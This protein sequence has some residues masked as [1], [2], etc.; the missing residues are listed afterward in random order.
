MGNTT[1][2]RA[3]GIMLACISLSLLVTPLAVHAEAT[4]DL[5]GAVLF[6]P[7]NTDTRLQKAV[8]MLLDE[9][10]RR[11]GLRW[12][13]THEWP[14]GDRVAVAVGLAS[15]L[16]AFPEAVTTPS[17]APEGYALRS[18][19]G[20]VIVA[21][22]DPRG[23]LFGVGRLLLEMRISRGK[24]LLA[25]GLEIFTAPK[26]PMRGHQLGYRPKVNTYDGWTPE[27]YEQYI[28]DLAVFGSNA[29]ELIPPRSD[30]APDSPHFVMPQIDMIASVS[31]LADDYGID[32]WM[33][34]PAM[35]V[36]F[37]K[38]E[39]VGA[40]LEE[41]ERVLSQ[42]PRVDA[43]FVPSG[44][45]G[46]LDPGPLFAFLEQAA[47]AVHRVHPNAQIWVSTQSFRPDQHNEFVELVRTRQPD[48]LDGVVFGPQNR[49]TLR[50]LRETL[51]PQY[52]IR[53]YPDITHS[54]KCQFP[55]PDWD[56][57][58]KLTEQ[59]EVINPRPTDFA[60]IIRMY[61]DDTIGFISY[62][63]GCNDDVNKFV[64]SAL[65]WNPDTP[66]IDVLRAYSRYFIGSEFE[67]AFA[68]G[69]LAL[70]RNWR[71]PLLANRG[72]FTTLAQFQD[73]ERGATPQQLLNWRFQ[74][75]LYRAYYDAYTARRLAYETELEAQALDVLRRAP[76][77]GAPL[78][79][80]QAETI[81]D[82]AVLEPVAQDLRARVFE[83]AE[84]LY[85]SIRMQ[86]S[87][88]RYRAIEVGRGA[89]LDLIDTP[90]NDRLWLKTRFA[91]IRDA[92]PLEQL[93]QINEI[94]NWSDPGPG[95]FYDR[96]GD[97]LQQAHLVRA[98]GAGAD[99]EYREAP[100]LGVDY[101]PGLKLSWIT[102][103]ETRY[104][105]PLRLQYD[106]LDSSAQYKVR[107][108]YAGDNMDAKMRLVAN[109]QIEVHPYIAKEQPIRPVE[110]DL[111]RE[112]TQSGG[113]T[114]SWT[115]EPG[116]RGGGRGCQVA[117]VWLIRK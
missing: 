56:P 25:D 40:A 41:W 36:N 78:A 43:V 67:D 71:G 94:V 33:W 15:A 110:F 58:F 18:G 28:R 79:M 20:R 80:Q 104:D 72:V 50:E 91:E 3:L 27:M 66:V 101:E 115:Q 51:P 107:V 95:G 69:L 1:L 32:F 21:G 75:G 55:V 5:S 35:G 85:Q 59:R 12:E 102:Y 99:P 57:A 96:L 54:I 2:H 29:I 92:R 63:E 77:L 98:P 81:L 48:F 7:A 45:P 39:T 23:V 22:N 60:N 26:Y 89:N 86:L 87:V 10:E 16:S 42:L 97:T 61:D 74:Q 31:Q 11:S 49:S 65:G 70:E 105:A 64:W 24:I 17:A 88:P 34:Y 106:G 30:D 46:R 109:G 82:R 47:P 44:D 111:P 84:A 68:Q 117:E 14:S 4:I 13:E 83:L 37:D 108:V 38:P 76:E 90:L 53:H 114:L 52:P 73:M 19:D 6:T 103:G 112:A 9:T 113:L 100:L 93:K 116:S 8:E 62:S